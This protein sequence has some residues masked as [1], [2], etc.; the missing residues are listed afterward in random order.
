MGVDED[1]PIIILASSH[2]P[3]LSE[4]VEDVEGKASQE[5][6]KI[7][8]VSRSNARSCEIDV[9]RALDLEAG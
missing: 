4:D 9:R 3:Q 2:T 6:M 7:G 5:A 1:T 8:V